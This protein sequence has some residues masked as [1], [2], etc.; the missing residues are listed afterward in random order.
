MLLSGV[1]RYADPWHPFRETSAELARLLKDQGMRVEVPDDVD[2]ALE[3][4]GDGAPM[5]DLLVVNVGLPHDGGGSPRTGEA[6]EG[7]QRWADS[8]VPLLAL[9]SSSMSFID[10]P[11]WATALGGRW[12][13]GRTMHP[14]Y[15]RAQILLDG[16]LFADL[17]DFTLDDERYS[18]LRTAEDVLV[19][20][21]H[22]HE[23]EAHPVAWSRERPVPCGTARSFYDALGHD[24]ASYASPEHRELL[25]RAVSW[26]LA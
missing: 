20:A 5:P 14:D 8:G 11:V 18:W 9:H 23:G 1:G 16:P 7:L 6:G 12:E 19:H 24:A 15:G 13:P 2:E 17:P 10:S 3:S 25:R 22:L 26:L 21:R 4:L